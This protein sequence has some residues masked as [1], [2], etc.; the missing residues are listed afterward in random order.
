MSDFGGSAMKKTAKTDSGDTL[1]A[2]FKRRFNK[3]WSGFKTWISRRR[4][5]KWISR[6]RHRLRFWLRH[7]GVSIEPSIP[8]DN[9]YDEKKYPGGLFAT[10][11][12][13]PRSAFKDER[14][15][16]I[17]VVGN[18]GVG[19]S[20]IIR[21]YNV[22]HEGRKKSYLYISLIDFSFTRDFFGTASEK[23]KPY[24]LSSSSSR[25][26]SFRMRFSWPSATAS[27]IVPLLS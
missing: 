9:L 22:L 12:C 24:S 17:A 14:V 16:N 15:R 20:S 21:S 18:Y 23:R 7:R 8:T 5:A 1:L 10:Y 25:R 4:F 3:R 19:K 27:R 11:E 13:R 26:C 2:D 6:S